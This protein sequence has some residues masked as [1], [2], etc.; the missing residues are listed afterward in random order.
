MRCRR[1]KKLIYLLLQED[2]E[3]KEKEELLKH[4]RDCKTCSLEWEEARRS[5]ILWKTTLSEENL[6]QISEQEL[7]ERVKK[8]IEELKTPAK[9]KLKRPKVFSLLAARKKLA[10]AG[11]VVI[12]AF[13]SLWLG[14]FSKGGKKITK[15]VVVHSAIIDEKEANFSISES[16]DKNVVLIW[17]EKS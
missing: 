4:L 11:A 13:L 2:L 1:A 6:P 8:R 14:I 9:E 7:P 10:Y 17:L 3:Q 16:E 5:Q 15:D 12:L